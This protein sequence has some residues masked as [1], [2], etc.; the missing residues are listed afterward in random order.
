M[1]AYCEGEDPWPFEYLSIMNCQTTGLLPPPIG[2][3]SKSFIFLFLNDLSNLDQVQK[4]H[5]NLKL[6]TARTMWK[7]LWLVNVAYWILTLSEPMSNQQHWVNPRPG[8][9]KVRWIRLGTQEK[10]NKRKLT[11]RYQYDYTTTGKSVSACGWWQQ[12]SEYQVNSSGI[13][14]F[15]TAGWSDRPS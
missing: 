3:T 12:N 1:K 7:Q 6:R 4:I 13:L 8:C 5:Y 15:A 9:S 11:W 14:I 10:V 2:K